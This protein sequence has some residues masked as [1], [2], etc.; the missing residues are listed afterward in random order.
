MSTA[1]KL[2]YLNDTKGLIK[3]SI[4]LGGGNLTTEPFRQYATTLKNIYKDFLANGIGTLWNNWEKVTGTGTSL[5]LSPTIQGEMEFTY[6]GNTSQNGTPTPTSPIPINVVSGDNKINNTGINLLNIQTIVKGRLDNGV[7]SYESAV[8]SLTLNDNGFSFTTN[9]NYRGV[10]TDYIPISG[11]TDITFSTTTDL[12]G[13]GQKIACYDKNKTYLGDVSITSPSEYV[14]KGT[15]LNNTQYIRM[16]W[17]LNSTGSVTINNPMLEEGNTETTYEPY[18]GHSYPLYLGVENLFSLTNIQNNSTGRTSFVVNNND[19]IMTAITGGT[20]RYIYKQID[21]LTIGQPYTIKIGSYNDTSTN[22]LAQWGITTTGGRY[23]DSVKTLS[24]VQTSTITPTETSIQFRIGYLTNSCSANDI[25]TIGDIQL[26]EGTKANSFTPYGQTPIELCKIGTYQD[27]IYKDNDSWYLHKEIGKV[28]LNG[29][30]NWTQF[31]PATLTN[32]ILCG[33][34]IIDNIPRVAY[35]GLS[36]YF[37]SNPSST[38][39]VDI[40]ALTIADTGTDAIRIR[41]NKNVVSDASA[42]E[43]WLS[44][45]NTEVYYVLATPTN[46]P[47]TD[48]TLINQLEESKLSYISQ[49]NISQVNNDLPFNLVVKALKNI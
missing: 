29:S 47:I 31:A 6:K 26:E 30:E 20:Y 35:I 39:N 40:E 36:N 9:A 41:I 2:T 32:T 13:T 21:N 22:K 43:T 19:I 7:V 3:D 49:T 8:T 46:T 33:T 12:T 38:W 5:S 37:K 44:T 28:V 45:H 15:T 25:L 14:R 4:N 42:L 48:T 10:T 24:N 11:I 18:I 23:Y 27:Y 34:N 17:I 1:D 16:H